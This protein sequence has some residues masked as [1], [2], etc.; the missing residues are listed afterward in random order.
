MRL[1]D[2]NTKRVSGLKY[3]LICRLKLAV[4]MVRNGLQEFVNDT[5]GT[6]FLEREL[7]GLGVGGYQ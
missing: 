5:D 1:L 7:M 3:K 2:V 6:A 4:D